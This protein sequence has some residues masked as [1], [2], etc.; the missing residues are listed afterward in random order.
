MITDWVGG[1]QKGQNI[2]YVIYGRSL[3]KSFNSKFH[4]YISLGYKET[5]KGPSI[6]YVRVKV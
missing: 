4:H 1:F 5:G 3:S 6:I 2:D